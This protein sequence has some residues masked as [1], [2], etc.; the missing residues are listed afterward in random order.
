[1][2]S[3]LEP[4]HAI[5]DTSE[6]MLSPQTLSKLCRVPVTR[7]EIQPMHGHSGLAGGQLS[8]VD[9]DAGR[10]VLKRMS[11]TSDWIMRVT[12]DHQGRSVR[13]WQYG[14]LDQLSPNVEHTIIAAARDGEGWAILMEDLSGKFFTRETFAPEF[15]P[16]VLDGLAKIHA[17]FWNDPRLQA[18]RLGL[19]NAATYLNFYFRSQN[20]TGDTWGLI[21]LWCRDGWKSLPELL[22]AETFQQMIDLHQHPAPLLN[23][24]KRY[25][26]TLLHGDYRAENL[27]HNGCLA[28][29]DWQQAKCSLMTID[30]AWITKHGYIQD[31]MSEEKAIAY[32]RSRLESHLGQSFDDTDWQA[33]VALGYAMDALSSACLFANFYTINGGA[34]EFSRKLVLHLGQKVMALRHWL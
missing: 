21:P 28:A 33:M 16:V 8:Y 34:D 2:M 27:A 31:V 5:F 12:E 14:L 25:P 17:T 22:D 7:V 9:T 19:G 13:L 18:P 29:I 10:F 11:I 32:Y 1:M 26:F 23:A 3:N 15:V 20:H 4:K 30:L 24:I 6:E